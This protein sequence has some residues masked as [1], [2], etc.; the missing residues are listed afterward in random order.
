M[1]ILGTND[2]A[3]ITPVTANLT[4]TNA[5]LTASGTVSITD[6]DSPAS[7]VAQTNVA[8][9]NGYGVFTLGTN[10]AW[11]YT[12]NTA[13]NEF[14][15]G[16]TY[17]DV[18]TVTSA[19]GTT[20]SITV[21][22]LG[23][24]D[25]PVAIGTN[26][27]GLE[28]AVSI[29]VVIEGTDVDGTVASFTLS[30]L[31]T[32]G[33]LYIDAALTILAATGTAYAATGNALN[34][35]FKPAANFNSGA[36][37][38][39]VVP[40]FNFTATDNSGGV[41]PTATETI[42]VTP[43]NDGTPVAVND[44]FQ[45]LV[46]TPITFTRAQLLGNDT[47]FDHAAI[48]ATSILPANVTYNAVSQT[49]TY[50][51][52]AV[53]AVAGGNST[54]TYTITDDDGQTSTATVNLTAYNSRDDLATV[55]ESALS[56]GTGGG[57]KV[58]SGALF[59]ND[60]TFTGNISNV[61]AG[62]NTT[63]VS[64]TTV[65]T[66]HTITTTY[67][68]LVVD[69]SVATNP[70][71]SY[72]YTLNAPVK[73]LGVTGAQV[74]ATNSEFVETFNYV[75]TGGNANLVVTITDDVPKVENSV[76]EVSS[77]PLTTFNLF[78]MLDVSG[79]ETVASASG[80]QRLIDANGGVTITSATAGFGSRFD[81]ALGTSTLAQTRDAVIALVSQYFDES[82]NVT[83]KFGT[84]S[85][86]ATSNNTVYT[87]KATAIAGINALLNT[88]GGTNYSAGLTAL[89]EMIGTVANPNDGVQRISYF[90]TDG[91]PGAITAAQ[92]TV[93]VTGFANQQVASD[94][95]TPGTSTG[96]TTF[97]TTNKIQSYGL[98]VGPAVPS[99]GP[100]DT[101]HNIDADGSNI[102][103]GPANNGKDTSLVVSDL[104]KLQQTLA[105]TVPPSYGGNIGGSGGGA[106]VKLGADGG[107]TQFIDLLLH[108]AGPGTAP[109]TLVRFT[110]DATT[111]NITNNNAAIAGA[112]INGASS[113]TLNA[114][115][116]FTQGL[117][118]FN[119]LTGNYLY[120]TQ[121][122]VAVGDKI[123]IGFGVIDKDGDTALGTN[124]I[125][126]VAGKPEAVSDFDTLTPS[127]LAASAKFFEGN[128][129]NAFGTDGG[130]SQVSGFKTGATGE[131]TILNGADVHSI[132]FKGVNFNL[133][134]A[135]ATPTALAGG[136][137]VVTA[138]GELTWTSSIEAA[139]VLVFHRDGYYKYTPPVAQTGTLPQ[140]AL[141]TL[142]LTGG[143]AATV[144]GRLTTADV[145]L[146]A[147]S[148]TDNLNNPANINATVSFN[149]NGVGVTT[150]TPT[151]GTAA[152]AFINDLENLSIV[153]NRTTYP[154]GVQNVS[155]TFNAIDSLFG[156]NGNGGI[157][158][159]QLS[160]YDIGG[161]LL[162]QE[163]VSSDGNSA[164]N[165]QA[166]YTVPAKY[167]DIGSIFIQPNSST[168]AGTTSVAGVAELQTVT[169]HK[170]LPA[171]TTVVAPDEVLQY[172]LTDTF[173][174]SSTANLTLHVVT[175]EYAG[176]AGNDSINGSASNDL[177]S[178]GAGDDTL[179]GAAGNDVIRGGAGNDSID[180][181]AGDDQLY[182]GDGNDTILGG[183]GNDYLYG[184]A[185]ND[186]LQGGDGNDTLDGGAGNDILVGGLGNDILIGG[187][188]NDTLTGG[189]GSDT[190][191]WVL[192]DK[193][194]AGT[195]ALDTI[196]DFD[197]ATA[198][199]GGDVLDLRDLLTGENHTTGTG[200]LSNYL[201]FEKIGADTVLHISSS[202]EFTAGYNAA[203]E[204]QTITLTGV[205]LVAGFSNDQQIIQDLLTKNKLITD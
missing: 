60:T 104:S 174:H 46:G 47:L 128:V 84:F 148:R 113:I 62:T 191:K 204:V 180:G 106:A 149:T 171:A 123:I 198:G 86:G 26:N 92:G 31:P 55:N 32:N 9:S 150:T 155:L 176:T 54:F 147:Y 29:P 158:A 153:F 179:N 121:G 195:P 156:N 48:T 24:N 183:I 43:V 181:G 111:G 160:I 41:S 89:Q 189:A 167:A 49:Y 8:G 4:E 16:T 99:T 194:A 15:A 144:G 112:T 30:S 70:T 58:A 100:L 82:G 74:G 7:F 27:T 93:S 109:D 25:G 116:G 35:Y 37:T 65:G 164:V 201:H 129:I 184:E 53:G 72:T 125:N 52:T 57:S 163:V 178:G 197:P 141:T 5:I 19:D 199:S 83:V 117:I 130:G 140:N 12:T 81:A 103:A 56:G 66:V 168:L 42:T 98:A 96:F 17:S 78:F 20:S 157:G 177:I 169:F 135:V 90:I 18:L 154:Q 162:G 108:S 159:V 205:D 75:R 152:S 203:K 88:G 173:A 175:N 6:V 102:Q 138:A 36:F 190:F 188:G 50:N 51:P 105:A 87:T 185:G 28:D 40:S 13:H 124:T 77:Q 61:T 120:Y 45:T 145:S 91:V 118:T 114:T 14:V 44:A 193:G 186:N 115:Q 38:G 22:I 79:S 101:V 196:T 1:A 200:N 143:N 69:Y 134:T 63:I 39:S 127:T 97:A 151:G 2:A 85:T 3:V 34:L 122:T 133:T 71:G 202:G 95:T 187:A 11:T 64:N 73:N 33:A 166:T 132:V 119:F 182:G 59:T 76:T 126:I 146:G 142:D 67:G 23:T 21:A 10:G 107:Y 139:N 165:P 161:N 110:Y 136:T 131:D 170:V 172:T 80:D 94:L 68:T 192:A 137:Y